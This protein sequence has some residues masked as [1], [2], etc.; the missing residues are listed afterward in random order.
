MARNYVT[1]GPGLTPEQI[2]SR[3]KSYFLRVLAEN[4]GFIDQTIKTCRTSRRWLNEQRETDEEFDLAVQTVIDITNESLLVEARRRA[5]GYQKPIVY[6]GK[7]QGH[8]VDSKGNI[9]GPEHKEARLVP[10][11]I[12]EV[13]D[14][15]LMFLIKGRMPEFRDGPGNKKG[16]DLTDEELNEALRKMVARRTG[17]RVAEVELPTEEAVN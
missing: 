12:T 16:V 17:K 3:K 5:L 2:E 14:N 13:S 8:Y 4:G 6:Q 9:V 11:T 1:K 15:L 10:A 7:I